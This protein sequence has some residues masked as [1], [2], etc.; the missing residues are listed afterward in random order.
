MSD[1]ATEADC[2]YGAPHPRFSPGLIGQRA[3]EDSFL[4]AFNAGR[5]HHA[6]LITGQLGVGKS[7]LAWRIAKFLLTRPRDDA[8]L[9]GAP[10]PPT[11]LDADPHHPV[12]PRIAALSEPRLF[13]LRRPWD[14]KS[15]RLRTEI[16]VD[17]VRRLKNYLSLSAADGGRRVVVVDSADEMNVSA[18][19]ALLKLLEEPPEDTVLLLVSHQPA[20]LLP[21]IL[22][23]CRHLRCRTLSG[24]EIGKIL[25]QVGVAGDGG[26]DALAELSAGSAGTALRLFTQDGQS[27]YAAIL[28][29]FANGFDRRGALKLAESSAGRG[30]AARFDLTLSLFDVMLSRLARS[31]LTGPLTEAVP[32]EADLFQRLSSTAS[33]AM[34]WATL[35]QDLS[36]RARHGQAVNLDPAALILD[37]TFKIHETAAASAA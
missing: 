22:S 5:L 25:S 32:G 34:R 35:Q 3:A 8:G 20:R 16:T 1:A 29:L 15:D 18:A 10:E 13:L 19:N 14:P 4:D 28:S 27:L 23:R 7:T 37:I 21:T 6:W 30:N 12:L 11:T 33:H 26:G 24:D 9:F 2:A 17:E 31:A 36:E